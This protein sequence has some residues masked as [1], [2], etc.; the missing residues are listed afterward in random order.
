MTYAVADARPPR[1]LP[2]GARQYAE[3]VHGLL[4]EDTFAGGNPFA[5]WELLSASGR[6]LWAMTYF[7]RAT[8]EP[9][10]VVRGAA[11]LSAS[12][13]ARELAPRRGGG[14]VGGVDLP[15]R[16]RRGLRRVHGQ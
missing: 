5:G 11:R 16:V 8:S 14:H 12:R 6:P 7:G 3:T 2:N 10:S 4:Y 9:A 15:Q 1:P 13:C